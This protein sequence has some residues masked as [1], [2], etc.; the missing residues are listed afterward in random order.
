MFIFAAAAATLMAQIAA[1]RS[2]L[3]RKI[4]LFRPELALQILKPAAR[5]GFANR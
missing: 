4:T 2:Q 5:T 1:E 3:A